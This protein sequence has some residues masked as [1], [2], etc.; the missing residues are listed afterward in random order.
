MHTNTQIRPLDMRSRN[1]AHI[2]SANFDMWDGSQN[3]AR[4]IPVV[5]AD[6]PVNL[7]KPGA[8]LLAFE[9]WPADNHNLGGGGS[10][11]GH[12]SKSVRSG[13]PQFVSLQRF[14]KPEL[15]SPR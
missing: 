12:L 13:A 4:A 14:K 1:A 10:N 3:P 6:L 8:P 2:R 7:V 5:A 9:N 15:Y 11:A